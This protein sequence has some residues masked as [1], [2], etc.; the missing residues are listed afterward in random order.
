MPGTEL[1]FQ[2]EGYPVLAVL[3]VV[4][5]DAFDEVDVPLQNPRPP[6]PRPA[7]PGPVLAK[8][9]PV[10]ADDSLRLHDDQCVGPGGEV[11]LQCR[12]EGTVQVVKARA[13]ILA[14]ENDKLLT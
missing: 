8:R 4:A 13:R 9:L 11:V 14:F 2:F 10:P 12:P 1:Q 6:A 7:F 3:G 5:R